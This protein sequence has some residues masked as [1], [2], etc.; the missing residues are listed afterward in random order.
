MARP[1]VSSIGALASGCADRH[2]KA[3]HRQPAQRRGR[4]VDPACRV[5]RH[6]RRRADHR[7]R[8]RRT[9]KGRQA[10]HVPMVALES[11]VL[12]DAMIHRVRQVAPAPGRGDLHADCAC[13]CAPHSPPRP[14]TAACSSACCERRWAITPPWIDSRRSRRR[15][16]AGWLKS[17]AV[18]EPADKRPKAGNRH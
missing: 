13:S 14:I 2:P 9:R 16:G 7:G 4:T 18:R 5:V 11:A 6:R 15:D 3:P 1:T 12:L 17:S 8:R 10:N